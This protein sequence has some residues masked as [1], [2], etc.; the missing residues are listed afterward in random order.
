MKISVISIAGVLA[1]GTSL[2][3]RM[4]SEDVTRT[5]FKTLEFRIRE[6]A[7]LNGSPPKDIHELD[8]P[9]NRNVRQ[10]NIYGIEIRYTLSGDTVTLKSIS[11]NGEELDRHSFNLKKR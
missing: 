8:K 7:K 1:I 4:G 3:T 11:P 5:A 6:Y 10:E 9:E 2:I